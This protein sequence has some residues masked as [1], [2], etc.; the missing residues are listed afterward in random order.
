MQCAGKWNEGD[1]PIFSFYQVEADHELANL[2]LKE[3]QQWR[4]S[5]R[6]TPSTRPKNQPISKFITIT[7]NAERGVIFRKANVGRERE[8]IGIVKTATIKGLNQC[9]ENG[10]VPGPGF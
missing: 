8:A 5:V 7:I 6:T 10:R 4:K 1:C 2:W 3:E 9:G